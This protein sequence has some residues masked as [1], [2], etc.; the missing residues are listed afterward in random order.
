MKNFDKQP[1]FTAEEI[2]AAFHE[3][4]ESE[5]Y[6]HSATRREVVS[7]LFKVKREARP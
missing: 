7:R 6:T 3:G 5:T 2:E 1:L 4:M